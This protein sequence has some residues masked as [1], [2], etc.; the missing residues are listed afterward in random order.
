MTPMMPG[1]T[2]DIVEMALMG[3]DTS[4][5]APA[6]YLLTRRWLP[7]ERLAVPA[8]A[9]LPVFLAVHSVITVWMALHMPTWSVDWLYQL[10]LIVVSMLFWLPVIGRRYRL[11][12][13]G[14][15]IYLFAAMPAMDL[16]AVFVVLHGDSA[17][18][19]AMIVAMLPVG[20]AAVATTWHWLVT[21]QPV[22]APQPL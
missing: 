21:E 7:W 11:G 1:S 16:A 5:V 19:L 15:M 20:L 13:G 17:G 2:S 6:L 22:A 10:A 3:L 14:R 18:G 8:V 12:P 9:A 4:L